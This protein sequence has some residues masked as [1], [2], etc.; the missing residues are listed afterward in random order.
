MSL[1]S[2]YKDEILKIGEQRR[3]NLVASNGSTLYSDVRLEK[4]YTP[5][6]EGDKFSAK[7]IND[8]NKAIN[9][10]NKAINDINKAI[11]DINDNYHAQYSLNERFTGRYWIDGKKVYEKV[12]HVSGFSSDISVNHGISNFNRALSINL[13]MANSKKD[14]YMIPRAHRDNSHDGISVAI[15]KTRLTIEVGPSNDFSNMNGYAIIK[16]TKTADE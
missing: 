12:L 14:N 6:V 9:D 4:A 7:D 3:Y 2:N 1:K 8:T 13:F 5:Q 15:T 16:Y 11:N 10:I